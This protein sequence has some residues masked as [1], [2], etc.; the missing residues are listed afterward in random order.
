AHPRPP[1]RA[2]SAT[3]APTRAKRFCRHGR[4]VG[5]AGRHARAARCLGRT[6]PAVRRRHRSGRSRR[7]GH[8][9]DRIARNPA[10]HR[11][12][13]EPPAGFLPPPPP[14]PNFPRLYKQGHALVVHATATPYRQRSHFDGQDVLES[15]RPGVGSVETGWLNRAL[16]ALPK[17]E[18][19]ATH[20]GLGIGLVTPLVLRGPAAVLGWAP[21]VVPRAGDDLAAR[22]WDLYQHRDRLLADKL[23]KGLDTDRLASRAGMAGEK[24]RGGSD[25]AEGMRLAAAGAARLL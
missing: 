10:G 21:P 24:A 19:V 20:G 14:I 17:G 7:C 12:R 3:V 11:A 15:G 1:E 13:R 22:V 23:G 18:R 6:R 16:A 25:N 5:V 2:R 8:R 4:R 9:S